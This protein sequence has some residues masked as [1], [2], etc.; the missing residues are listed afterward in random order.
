MC[1]NTRTRKQSVS[2]WGDGAATNGF[3]PWG[4]VWPSAGTAVLRRRW[5]GGAR[6]VMAMSQTVVKQRTDPESGLLRAVQ[7][8]A[9]WPRAVCAS[10]RGM[11]QARGAWRA[12][13]PASG[14]RRRR[15]RMVA[16]GSVPG[17]I[18]TDASPCVFCFL[19]FPTFPSQCWQVPDHVDVLAEMS[20]GAQAHMVFS[21]VTG[22]WCG[23]QGLGGWVSCTVVLQVVM[24]VACPAAPWG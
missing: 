4:S 2:C 15:T 17:R 19:F 22:A 13:I 16:E 21:A 3:G 6:R 10:L 23:L 14:T 8:R 11:A 18:V 24:E 7:V 9:P 1:R 5:V 12:L 20:C